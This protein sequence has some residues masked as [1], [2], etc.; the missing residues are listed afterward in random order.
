MGTQKNALIDSFNPQDAIEIGKKV[1]QVGGV[2]A[3]TIIGVELV[4][5]LTL[6]SRDGV[7]FQGLASEYEPLPKLDEHEAWIEVTTRIN[8]YIH[9]NG[10]IYA[11]GELGGRKLRYECYQFLGGNGIK[12]T[13]EVKERLR[14]LIARTLEVYRWLK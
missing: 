6:K 14:E 3:Y 2:E 8:L 12:I 4:P 9:Q 11:A 13:P 7:V 1:R 5:Q 10:V